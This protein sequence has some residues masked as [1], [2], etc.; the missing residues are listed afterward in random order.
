MTIFLVVTNEIPPLDET[1]EYVVLMFL[2]GIGG[3][4]VGIVMAKEL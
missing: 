3:F 1:I 2:F 4:L